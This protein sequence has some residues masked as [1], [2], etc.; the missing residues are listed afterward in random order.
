MTLTPNDKFLE[1][2]SAFVDGEATEIERYRILKHVGSDPTLRD[3]WQRYHL[4]GSAMRRERQQ[5]SQFDI[6]SRVAAALAAEIRAEDASPPPVTDTTRAAPAWRDLALKFGVAASVAAVVV[7]GLSRPALDATDAP[8]LASIDLP[9]PAPPALQVVTSVPTGFEV[10]VPV[11]RVVAGEAA[12]ESLAR[13]QANPTHD[14]TDPTT[15]AL[16][17]RLLMEHAER[18]SA[19][20]SLGLL[21][22]ARVS[23]MESGER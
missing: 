19:N 17:N 22:F 15:Q 11:G 12:A 13:A 10:P 6:S 20:G 9:Q 16:L 18:A 1:S 23:H 7:L 14:L 21:P 2:L 5:L 8:A 4:I 3:K